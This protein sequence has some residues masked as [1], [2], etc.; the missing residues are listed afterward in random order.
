MN[1]LDH[2]VEQ[3]S[4]TPSEKKIARKAFD[5]ALERQCASIKAEAQEMIARAGAPSEIWRVHDYLSEQRRKIDVLYDYR[6]S[7]LLETF[8]AALRDG[9]LTEVDLAGLHRDK[10]D[11]I[12][13]FANF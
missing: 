8:G 4:W 2:F 13:R 3:I 5:R 10:I 6:Y 1:S 11:R 7:V 9:W 12:K